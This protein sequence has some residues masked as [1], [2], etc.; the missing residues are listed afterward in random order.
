[1]RDHYRD[2]GFLDAEASYVTEFA[3]VAREKLEVV[4]RVN[5]GTRYR[6]GR[7]DIEGYEILTLEEIRAVMLLQEQDYLVSERVDLDVKKLETEYGSR[8]YIDARVI[9]SWVFSADVL[10]EVAM[11]SEQQNDG[12][13]Q[14]NIAVEQMNQVTQQAAANAEESAGVAEE[15]SGQAESLRQM[16]KSFRLNDRKQ[17]SS[18]DHFYHRAILPGRG[19]RELRA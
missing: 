17:D 19:M 3:D 18:P 8:G 12:V 15:L 6:V 11:A 5:E 13:G 16:V 2:R 4:F 9:S 1:M 14:I 7:I 10:D